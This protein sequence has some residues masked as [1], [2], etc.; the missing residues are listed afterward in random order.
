MDSYFPNPSKLQ[1]LRFGIVVA[2]FIPVMILLVDP[3]LSYL[4][5][6]QE[7]LT[8]GGHNVVVAEEERELIS[9][10]FDFGGS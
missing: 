1:G 9:L 7:L 6:A 2:H 4:D 8:E 3:D 10:C 5:A